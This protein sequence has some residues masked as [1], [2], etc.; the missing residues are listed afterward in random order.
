MASG[1]LSQPSRGAGGTVCHPNHTPDGC[2]HGVG[3]VLSKEERGP[4]TTTRKVRMYT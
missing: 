2:G 3:V 4:Y 1:V